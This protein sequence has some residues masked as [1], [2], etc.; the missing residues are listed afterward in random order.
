MQAPPLTEVAQAFLPNRYHYYY[1]RSK[2]GSDP[3]YGGVA[4]SLRGT[5]APLLDLGCGLGLLAHTLR[6]HGVRLD[7]YLGVDNDRAKIE[8]AR[9][10]AARTGIADARFDVVDLGEGF[11]THRGSVTILDMLQFLSPT[12]RSQLFSRAAACLEPGARLVIRTGL[13]D[14]NWRSHVT[15]VSD[16]FANAVRWMNA[17]PKSYPTRAGLTG[18]L[19]ALGLAV[20][21]RP[22]WGRTPFNNWLFVAM[23]VASASGRDGS[24]AGASKATAAA[25]EDASSIPEGGIDVPAGGVIGADTGTGSTVR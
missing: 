17:A 13:A 16:V 25:E 1:A 21:S 19:E 5:T 14:G 22:L 3:L 24:D 2:L 20:S 8:A 15:R 18:E 4:D 9:V 10:A 6:R 23:P 11:P 12:Q 7:R